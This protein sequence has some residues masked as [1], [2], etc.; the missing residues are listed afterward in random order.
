MTDVSSKSNIMMPRYVLI[1]TLVAD[2][3]EVLEIIWRKVDE[4]ISDLLAL[5]H[6]PQ[7]RASL[8]NLLVVSQKVILQDTSSCLS[9]LC[10]VY[11]FNFY[12][13]IQFIYCSLSIN[14]NR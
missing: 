3:G 13:H 11:T 14:C 2:R 8:Q 6:T 4:H 9:A 5:D 7:S 10:M 12:L 1:I